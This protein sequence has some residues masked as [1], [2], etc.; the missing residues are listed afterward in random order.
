M[1]A[2]MVFEHGLGGGKD[3]PLPIEYAIAGAGAALAVSF[4]VLALAWRTPR[5]DAATQGRP[6]WPFLADLVESPAF[7]WTVRGVALA[8]TA[9]VGWAAVAGPDLVVNP[10]FG[11]VYV[12]LWVGLVPASLLFG[13]FYRAVNPIRTLHLLLSRATGLDPAQGVVRLP[14]WVGIWP[15][16]FGLLAFVWLELVY[17]RATYLMDLRL[18]M[19][20]YVAVVFLGA[21]IFGDKW[22]EAADPFEAFSTLVGRL[23]VFGRL[24]DGS[25]VVRM[26]LRNLDATPPTPGISGVVAVLFGSTAYD[27]FRESPRWVS[28]VQSGELG[29]FAVDFLTRTELNALCLL[30]FVLAVLITF[31]V[32]TMLT[33]VHAGFSRWRLPNLFAHSI[34]PIIVGYFVAHY[35]SYFVIVGQQT[36]IQ[37]SDPMVDG[38]NYLGTAGL[39]VNNWIL[40]HPQLLAVVKVLAIVIGHLVAVVAAHDRAIK[41]LPKRHQLTGQLSLLVVMV[42][43]TVTGLYLLLSS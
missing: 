10:F 42:L 25:L 19:A 6:M 2:D 38:S 3:L 5:F 11:V 1:V 12:L 27:S 43:Y 18:W 23:S 26:P 21:A 36:V 17:P 37:L 33:G 30:F 4:I 22:I 14:S 28:V 13:P 39:T 31:S 7:A 20:V 8:F 40:L 34:V 16:A 24:A 41:L 32:A 29:P 35:L 15:A 9:Y